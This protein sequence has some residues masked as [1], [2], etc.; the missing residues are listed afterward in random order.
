MNTR[1]SQ[2]DA[3]KMNE[4]ELN[5][6]LEDAV[7]ELT[8]LTKSIDKQ[9]IKVN[10]AFALFNIQEREFRMFKEDMEKDG[11]Y[12]EKAI[13]LI[14]LCAKH[15]REKEKREKMEKKLNELEERVQ[16]LQ[17]PEAYRSD[18]SDDSDDDKRMMMPAG[19]VIIP[20]SGGKVILIKG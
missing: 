11:T 8:R 6:T 10:D 16:K 7:N 18:E 19:Q 5:I 3:R 9:T 15:K 1:S 12:E 13:K 17:N 4:V 14:K 2:A 20:D